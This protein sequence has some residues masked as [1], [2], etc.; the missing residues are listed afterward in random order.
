MTTGACS[1]VTTVAKPLV[2]TSCTTSPTRSRV[3]QSASRE[4][5]EVLPKMM[6]KK[7]ADGLIL[8]GADH[9]TLPYVKTFSG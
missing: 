3:C 7:I 1:T 6:K 4:G 2:R 5:L 9:T 8:F